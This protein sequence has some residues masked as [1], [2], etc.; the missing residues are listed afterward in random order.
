MSLAMDFSG[1]RAT[2]LCLLHHRHQLTAQ[3]RAAR[4]QV[5]GL[6]ASLEGSME[7]VTG[8]SMENL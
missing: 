4:V 3:L 7:K 8:K 1:L 5:T 6:R 2:A